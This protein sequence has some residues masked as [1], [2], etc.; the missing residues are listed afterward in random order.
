MSLILEALKKSEAE[1]QRGKA[2][3][4][5]VEQA[6]LPVRGRQR[7]PGWAYALGVLLVVVV[8]VFVWREWSRSD[9]PGVGAPPPQPSP[10]SGGGSPD[11]AAPP[12]LPPAGEGRGEGAPGA[13]GGPRRRP[14]V[15]ASP[16]TLK[17]PEIPAVSIPIRQVP[18]LS[19]TTVDRALHGVQCTFERLGIEF[20]RGVREAGEENRRWLA[21]GESWAAHG[22]KGRGGQ[23][24]SAQKRQHL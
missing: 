6:V 3:G 14:S 7:T 11:V 22:D 16:S 18:G 17:L 1:R 23:Q 13:G 24:K 4:L 8:G 15:H 10:A 9:S 20:R 19:G 21:G 12:P 5:F 2:P